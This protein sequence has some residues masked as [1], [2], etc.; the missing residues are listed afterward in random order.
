MGYAPNLGDQNLKSLDRRGD[1]VFR[2]PD[3]R[4]PTV[5]RAMQA[6][7]ASGGSF[8]LF[9]GLVAVGMAIAGLAGYFPIYMG[10]VA[11]IAVGFALLAQ[12][13]TLAS[14]W[15]NAEHIPSTERSE[16]VG[17]GT[18]VLGGF[19]GIALGVLALLGV[20]SLTLLPV[21]AIV[22][23]GA[24]LLGGPAQ[25]Q[26]ADVAPGRR[27]VSRNAL[28]TSSSVMVMAGLGAMVL[29]VLALATTGYVMVM[30]LIAMLSIAGA[31]VLAGGAVTARF[32][33]RFA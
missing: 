23:G 20:A 4:D 18:E 27:R 33:R 11:T 19:A 30:S 16:A 7:I 25:P 22:V 17:I 10:A 29:G 5:E 12:G 2:A 8:E 32:A 9:A 3:Y 28:R 21:A 6:E 24:L 15:Q 14:R 1:V 26:I 31:L 13:G